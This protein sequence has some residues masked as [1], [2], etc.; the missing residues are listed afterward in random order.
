MLTLYSSDYYKTIKYRE[1]NKPTIEDVADGYAKVDTIIIIRNGEQ[2][3]KYEIVWV[4]KQKVKE[5]S[6][7]YGKENN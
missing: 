7:D 4:G 3:E 5:N 2:Q 6:N 1:R